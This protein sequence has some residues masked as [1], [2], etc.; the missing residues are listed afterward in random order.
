AVA[1]ASDVTDPGAAERLVEAALDG[2][3]RLDA[4]VLNAGVIESRT[5]AESSEADLARIYDVNTLAAF[6]LTRAALPSLR[7]AGAGRLVYTTSTAGLYGGEGLA[8]YSM[9]KGALLGLMRAVAAEEARFGIRANAVCPTAVTRMTEAFVSDRAMREALAPERVAPAFAWL[10]SAECDLNGRTILAAGGL[11]RSAHFLAN[12]GVDLRGLAEIG[13][14]DVAACSEAITAATDLH[15]HAHAG[16]HFG[17]LVE[18]LACPPAAN[19]EPRP[20]RRTETVGR[21]EEE[22]S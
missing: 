21:G 2:F 8:A 7:R 9:A 11:F 6:R 17:A 12:E 1:V 10:A 22:N 3:G 14:E 4:V 19:R 15:G 20:D 13:P 18:E 16:A 5:V